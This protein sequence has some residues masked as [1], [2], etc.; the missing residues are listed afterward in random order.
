MLET[1][2]VAIDDSDCAGRAVELA[3][4][5]ANCACQTVT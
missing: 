3:G 1:I 2:L 4:H 5:L